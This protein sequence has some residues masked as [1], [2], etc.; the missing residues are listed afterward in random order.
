MNLP[1]SQIIPF[2]WTLSKKTV[3]MLLKGSH[4]RKAR[5]PTETRLPEIVSGDPGTEMRHPMSGEQ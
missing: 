5:S 3:H 2:R 1:T 4:A